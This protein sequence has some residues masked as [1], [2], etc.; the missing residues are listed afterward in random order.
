MALVPARNEADRVAATIAA[1]RRLPGL[2]EVLLVDDGRRPRAELYLRTALDASGDGGFQ[3]EPM[4]AEIATQANLSNYAFV[5]LN[6]VSNVPANLEASFKSTWAL[7]ALCWS[8]WVLR[9]RFS[10]ESPCWTSLSGN[11]ATPAAKGSDS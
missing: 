4:R 11:P 2:D 7:E 6:D 8:H 9:L 1:L 3:L 10:R 5:I